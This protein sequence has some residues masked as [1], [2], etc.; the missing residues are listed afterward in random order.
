[1]VAEALMKDMVWTPSGVRCPD[2]FT[3]KVIYSFLLELI[4]DSHLYVTKPI[5]FHIENKTRRSR[6]GTYIAR[7]V[8]IGESYAE[9]MV[10]LQD[11]VFIETVDPLVKFDVSAGVVNCSAIPSPVLKTKDYVCRVTEGT[12]S[13]ILKTCTGCGYMTLKD[14][15]EQMDSKFFP[16]NT[17]FNIN[18]YVR[19]IPMVDGFE[20]I[21]I[22][23]YNGMTTEILQSLLLRYMN[24]LLHENV[25]EEEAEWAYSFTL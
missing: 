2:K 22:R 19:V 7:N 8:Q 1:M 12:C 21:K 20:N 3:G 17:Y 16:M 25:S 9:M 13:I 6:V 11:K 24:M 4:L 5:G 14:T 10:N 23:Y 15:S 18:D